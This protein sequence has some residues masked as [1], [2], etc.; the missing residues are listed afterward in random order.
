MPQQKFTL[1]E[2]FSG[3]GLVRAG[4]GQNWTTCFAND[5]DPKK[6][7]AYRENFGGD[8]L[9]EGDIANVHTSLLQQQ[10]DLYWASSPCQD[11]SLAGRRRGL[12]GKKS[13]AFVPWINLVKRMVNIGFGPKIIAFENVNGLISSNAGADFRAVITAFQDLNYRVGAV[14]IDA[15]IF[16]PQSRPRMFVIAARSD[17]DLRA[18][19]IRRSPNLPFHSERL[20]KFVDALPKAQKDNW[21][22]WDIGHDF[23]P[24]TRLV[25]CLEQDLQTGW[26]SQQEVA[27]YIALMSPLHRQRILEIQ[28][29]GQTTVGTIYKRG[30]V[31]ETGQIRQRVEI[32]LDGVAGCLRTPGGGSSR[33]T[34]V[35]VSPNDLRM[36]LLTA[37]EAARLMGIHDSYILPNNYNEAYKIS[38]DGV[39]VPVVS[40][41]AKA[42]FEPTLVAQRMTRA[43]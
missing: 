14:E 23:L 4:L 11:F 9:V 32:R 20:V 27:R 38:G 6:C 24:S 5:I 36:R 30:R 26:L 22:W 13:G 42:I 34:V 31:D 35:F 3:G 19:P 25:D 40:H 21:L 33:Q 18:A 39:A 29:K 15:R 7:R 10:I 28:A 16:L 12:S 37:R 43:A 2:F 41:L 8:V 1:A 17:L